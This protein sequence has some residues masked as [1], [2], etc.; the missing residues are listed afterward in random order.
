[1]TD[2]RVNGEPIGGE[3]SRSRLNNRA[4]AEANGGSFS[5]ITDSQ[6]TPLVTRAEQ[7]RVALQESLPDYGVLVFESHHAP[8]F[9]MHWRTHT[10]LKVVYVLHGSGTFDVADESFPFQSGDVMVIPPD[11]PNRIRDDEGQPASLYAACID[12]PLFRGHQELKRRMRVRRIARASRSTTAIASTLRRMVFLQD[13]RERLPTSSVDL[14]MNAWRLVRQVTERANSAD[15]ESAPD[16]AVDGHDQSADGAA[17]DNVETGE[18]SIIADY[19]EQLPATFLDA[20]TIDAAAASVGLPRR[21]FTRLF[22]EATGSTWLQ[23]IRGLGVRHAATL[24]VETDLPIAQI[25]FEAGF[26]D[27]STFYRRF[28]KTTGVSPA[29]YRSQNDSASPGKSAR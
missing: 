12:H 28:T 23:T 11:T 14:L 21:T 24:L 26:A 22:R 8:D 7:V 27:L 4:A 19:I 18:R 16:S 20:T 25:A 9:S 2:R 29:T 6:R 15:A 17:G 3:R 5:A 10:F 13:Q 1:M